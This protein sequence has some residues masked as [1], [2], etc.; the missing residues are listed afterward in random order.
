MELFS[1]LVAIQEVS[2]DASVSRRIDCLAH[3]SIPLCWRVGGVYI[4]NSCPYALLMFSVHISNVSSINK[5]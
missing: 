4:I 1:Y 3:L 5:V 2:Y